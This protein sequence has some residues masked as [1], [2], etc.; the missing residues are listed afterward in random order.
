MKE[1]GGYIEFEHY[2]GPML[3]EDGIKLDSGRSCLA[4][5]IKAKR[6]RKIAIPSF[7]CNS[8]FNMCLNY[9]VKLKFYQVGLDFLPEDLSLADDEYLY[10]VNYYGQ[11]SGKSIKTYREKYHRVIIDNTQAYFDDPIPGVD[12]F[13]SCRKFFGVPDGGIL[14]TDAKLELEPEY[15]ESWQN[16]EHLLGRFERNASEFYTQS[17]ANNKRF[18]NQPVR[19]MSKLTENLLHGIDYQFV[20]KVRTDN[21]RCLMNRLSSLNLLNLNP[22]TGAFSYPLMLSEAKNL[23]KKLIDNKVFVP[24]LWPDVINSENNSVMDKNLAEN[25]LPLPCDQR[26]SEYEMEFICDVILKAD[27]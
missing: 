19:K 2:H 26:Y 7:M 27:S 9:D 5:L 14:Y 4:Y 25:I 16:M 12:T 3:H 22:V 6:I 8:V 17:T 23:R 11:L 13:Y 24:K 15:S 21:Y 1:I 18:A 20:K 10:L